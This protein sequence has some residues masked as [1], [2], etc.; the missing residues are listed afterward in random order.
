MA[1]VADLGRQVN[2]AVE[3]DVFLLGSAE[4]SEKFWKEPGVKAVMWFHNFCLKCVD[5][6][7]HF[8]QLAPKISTSHDQVLYGAVDLQHGASWNVTHSG[9]SSIPACTTVTIHNRFG[10]CIYLND[11]KTGP[12]I[13]EIRHTLTELMKPSAGPSSLTVASI[14]LPPPVS[15]TSSIV[16]TGN[17]STTDS[18][19]TS[20][21]GNLSATKETKEPLL[22]AHD[23]IKSTGLMTKETNVDVEAL[24]LGHPTVAVPTVRNIRE[25]KQRKPVVD[26]PTIQA[27]SNKV[28]KPLKPTRL[29]APRSRKTPASSANQSINVP[30]QDPLA[31]TQPTKPTAVP[32]TQN[33]RRRGVP[34]PPMTEKKQQPTTALTRAFVPPNQRTAAR[35][36]PIITKEDND[37]TV[38]GAIAGSRRAGGGGASTAL[39]R[40]RRAGIP[41]PSALPAKTE[42][43]KMCVIS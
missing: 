43:K 13:P 17:P 29:P 42:E 37:T 5:F 20:S 19:T 25:S 41:M 21:R 39:D 36:L 2:L 12:S 9:L 40:K 30:Q 15:A 27:E 32:P 35:Q 31:A 6:L 22:S 4:V 33:T 3:H 34:P 10:E 16:T 14:P 8:I 1:I 24:A 7:P 18:H 11:L 38:G 28:Q 23:E 26:L